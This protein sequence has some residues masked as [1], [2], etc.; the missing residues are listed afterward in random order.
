MY[1]LDPVNEIWLIFNSGSKGQVYNLRRGKY[2]KL[3]QL[4]NLNKLPVL[5]AKW[6][7]TLT[8]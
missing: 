4:V 3:S 7:H 1:L 2:D 8:S 5:V 6:M